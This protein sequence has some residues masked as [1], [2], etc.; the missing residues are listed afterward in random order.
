M[1]AGYAKEEY[2]SFSLLTREN[3]KDLGKNKNRN[4]EANT[5]TQALLQARNNLNDSNTVTVDT[6]S[7]LQ[8]RLQA[9]TDALKKLKEFRK[10]TIQQVKQGHP[11]HS[12]PVSFDLLD[13]CWHV[14][15]FPRFRKYV[16][17][18][19]DGRKI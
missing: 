10:I 2:T 1:G 3:V 8:A 7:S 17:R 5:Q 12:W 9:E 18:L 19:Q 15:I 14:P 6:V 16:L 13:T 11:T 4:K